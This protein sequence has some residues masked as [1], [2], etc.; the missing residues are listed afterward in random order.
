MLS[1]GWCGSVDWMPVCKPK[2]H[3]FNSQSGHMPG[4]QARS[5]V[6][7]AWEATTDWCFSPSLSLSL[8]L[9][10]KI[11]KIFKIRIKI[12]K[13]PWPVWLSWLGIIL[14]SKR[15]PVQFPVRTHTWVE[16]SRGNWSMFLSHIN[17]SLSLSLCRCLFPSLPSCLPLCLKMNS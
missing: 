9:S 7:G 11:N 4:L 16:G 6:G 2:G 12:I 3:Q 5:P 1:S 13:L 14:Q 17:V 8:T 10:L 15:S